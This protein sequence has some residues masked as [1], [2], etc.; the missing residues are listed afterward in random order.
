MGRL[1]LDERSLRAIGLSEPT[2]ATF[3]KLTEFVE[4]Q[5]ALAATQGALN[6]AE[7]DIATLTTAVNA[8]T[9]KNTTQDGRLD[10]LE[11]A[12][13]YVE[14]DGAAAPA[15]TAYAGQDVSAAYVEAEAQATDDA[16]AALATVVETLITR[17]QTANVLS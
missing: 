1:Y 6:A 9:T 16:V 5:E 17:L 11:A 7:V 3:R 15:Y 4:A 14:Q 10:T 8:N 13:P 2:I 12:G